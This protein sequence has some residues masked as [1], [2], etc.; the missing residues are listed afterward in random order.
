MATILVRS[1][2]KK[3]LL[4]EGIKDVR[5]LSTLKDD[6]IDGLQNED[7]TFIGTLI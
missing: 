1:N 4:D 7:K 3:A 2:R 6:V 5:H